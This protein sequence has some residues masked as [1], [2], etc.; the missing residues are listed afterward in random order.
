MTRSGD[1]TLA[2]RFDPFG[3]RGP[4]GPSEVP[5]PYHRPAP[6]GPPGTIPGPLDPRPASPRP[7]FTLPESD[8]RPD[9]SQAARLAPARVLAY[10]TDR[11][12]ELR[13]V[14]VHGELDGERA[15]ELSARLMTLDAFDNAPISLHLRTH[16]ADLDAALT[17][18][19]TIDVLRCPV[20]A[21]VAGQVGGPA[22]AVL[23]AAQRRE[24]TRHATLRLFEPKAHDLKGNAE[25]LTT[26]EAEHERLVRAFYTRLG[27]VT[28]RRLEEIADDARRG[29]LFTATEALAYGLIHDIP[30]TAPPGLG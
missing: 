16:D 26:L 3:P 23:A 10:E 15:T 29:R 2:S 8:P 9:Q 12:L 7:G 28:G 4:V 6:N 19:D 24:M 25:E 21:L 17:V 22:L 18:V 27:E 30:G 13:M 20:H 1:P 11:L 14:M 5:I